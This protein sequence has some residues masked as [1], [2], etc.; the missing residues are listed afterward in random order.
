MR[1]DKQSIGSARVSIA[2]LLALPNEAEVSLIKINLFAFQG[3]LN[4]SIYDEIVLVRALGPS[5]RMFRTR[6]NLN[7]CERRGQRFVTGEVKDS[8]TFE[9]D[10]YRF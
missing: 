7:H 9:F 6:W 2:K 8:K 1:Q 3:E 10:W 5:H 4:R